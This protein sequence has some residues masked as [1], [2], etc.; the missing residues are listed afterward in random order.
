MGESVESQ[1]EAL[2]R[3][4]RE[5]PERLKQLTAVRYYL[6]DIIRRCQDN[7]LGRG[8]GITNY[9][10]FLDEVEGWRQ[11]LSINEIFLVTFNYDTIL[12]EALAGDSRCQFRAGGMRDYVIGTYK[13]IKPHGSINWMHHISQYRTPTL[14]HAKNTD[15]M[16]EMLI[17]GGDS[18]QMLPPSVLG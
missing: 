7:W 16:K 5:N 10:S 4:G 18:L 3:E 2:L 11:S 17:D 1:L 9:S 12:E 14:E 13:V 15:Q 8:R 6:Q